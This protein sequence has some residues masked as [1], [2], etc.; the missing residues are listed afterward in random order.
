MI[1][2]MIKMKKQATLKNVGKG[3]FVI[4]LYYVMSFL[5][6]LPFEL[7][8]IDLKEVP[9]FIKSIY[10]ICYEVLMIAIM[11]LIYKDLV[12]EKWK[13]LKKNHN[14]YF[15][16]YFKLWYL[17]LG[18]MMLSNLIIM[19]VTKNTDG[20]EN[21][22]QIIELFG[23]APIYTYIS[24]VI[25][26][27]IIEEIVF[28]QSIRMIIPKY[29]WLFILISGFVFGG[30]HVLGASTFAEF[31]YIIPYSI[32]GLIFAYILTKTDNI[33]TTIGL[34]FVHNGVLMSLQTLLFIF[35]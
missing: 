25:F 6:T 21:Q 4:L 13:D 16:K 1:M 12:L 29:N 35:G 27:P 18:L 28:R 20:A 5:Q 33:F 7:F 17:L 23:K 32:P 11:L 2:E 22:A 34:H 14:L 3:L 30:M 31:I 8:N 24:A 15:K 10:L 9:I 19:V 26:A